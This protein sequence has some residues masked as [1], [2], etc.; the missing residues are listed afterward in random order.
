MSEG[1]KPNV[2]G[3]AVKNAI[4]NLK[5]LWSDT[6]PD[7]VIDL[8]QNESAQDLLRQIDPEGK[9]QLLPFKLLDISEE[10]Q[11]G[12]KAPTLNA[13]NDLLSISALTKGCRAAHLDAAS[14]HYNFSTPMDDFL[15]QRGLTFS[16]ENH[17]IYEPSN[18]HEHERKFLQFEIDVALSLL[19][20]DLQEEKLKQAM[21]WEIQFREKY[22]DNS[23]MQQMEDLRATFGL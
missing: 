7:N 21:K 18:C 4:S 15:K 22:D 20:L 9:F 1:Q 2:D 3:E 14:T 11:R 17:G 8:S 5:M 6:R 13:L 23:F 16:D 10:S 19:M 12:E